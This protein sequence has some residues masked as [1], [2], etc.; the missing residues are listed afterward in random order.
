VRAF[1]WLEVRERAPPGYDP[2][3][4]REERRA[5]LARAEEAAA[6]ADRTERTDGASSAGGGR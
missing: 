2:L 1:D 5:A 4:S 3:A 6:S